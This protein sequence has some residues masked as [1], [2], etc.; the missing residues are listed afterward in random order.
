MKNI[1]TI[2]LIALSTSSFAQNASAPNINIIDFNTKMEIVEWLCHYDMV[3]WVTS[4]SVMEQDEKDLARL[5]AEWFCIQKDKE[6]H[7]IYGKFEN[8]TFDLVFH[9]KVD[10]K[11]NISKSSEPID[12]NIL[13]R[14]SR[15]LQTANKQLEPMKDTISLRFNHYI[16]ENE[17]KTLTVWI[18]PAFQP[19][20][21]AIYG[22]EFIYTIDPLGNTILK[23]ESYFPKPFRGFKVGERRPIRL[24]YKDVEKPTLGAIFFAWYYKEY[25]TEVAIYNSKTTSMPFK[26]ED[27][28]TWIHVE[29]EEIS[30]EEVKPCKENVFSVEHSLLQEIMGELPIPKTN[31]TFIGGIEE[32]QKYFIPN[33]LTDEKAKSMFFK[34]HIG[35]LVNCEGKA[36]NFVVISRG[37]GDLETYANQV[38]S[39]VSKMPQQ[40]Q[41]ATKK[42]KPV[43]CYQ[44]ISITVKEGKLEKISYR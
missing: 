5:G 35:F 18:L 41:P 16:K 44:V 25:F 33:P 12:T 32:L 7:A 11:G 39:I 43:D 2:L 22:G 4:D 37:K 17:D 27:G 10:D 3:A 29:R 6:W 21:F 31:P 19:N 36:G 38:L 20:N 9:F 28:Y 30:I 15:A 14:Y 8:N 13:N 1:L 24:N 40:W 42:Q 34:V 23:D 26:V